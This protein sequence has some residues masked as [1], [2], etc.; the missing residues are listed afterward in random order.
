MN[1]KL[2]GRVYYYG[3]RKY[4]KPSKYDDLNQD[5]KYISLLMKYEK[6]TREEMG[7]C[8]KWLVQANS[9][10]HAENIKN[11]LFTFECVESRLP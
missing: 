6:M 7:D 9:L 4:R 3:N 5:I 8:Y 11:T 2:L 1:P 10:L